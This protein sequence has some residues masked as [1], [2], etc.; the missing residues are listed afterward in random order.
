LCFAG[1]PVNA[2]SFSTTPFRI[3][4]SINVTDSLNNGLS[5]FYA[6]VKR[7]KELLMLLNDEHST[8]VFFLVDEI[9]RGTNNRVRLQGSRAF[10]QKVAGQNGIGLVSTHDL[11]LAQ[12]EETIPQLSNWH[13][14]ETIEGG[15]MSFEYK[16]KP[17]PCP[18]TNALKIMEME[19]L[20]V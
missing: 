3:F 17:G 15:K 12:L 7:L 11:E 10:L 8:P 5:H 9:Y 16:L 18:T 1:A 2:T 14:E 13:F 6:E 4:S 19:G 20:P